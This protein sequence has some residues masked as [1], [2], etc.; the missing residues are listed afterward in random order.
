MKLLVSVLAVTAVLFCSKV[1]AA[2]LY[3]GRG[4]GT[5]VNDSNYYYGGSR[6]PQ[7]TATIDT[8]FDTVTVA[9]ALTDLSAMLAHDRLWIDSRSFYGE[10]LSA[11]EISNIQAF[12]ATGRRTVLMGER[13]VAWSTQ[14]LSIVGG[15]WAG[16]GIGIG[17]ANAL[18]VEPAL[19]KGVGSIS[20][21]QN[22]FGQSFGGVPLF[23]RPWSALWGD[24]TL[25]ILDVVVFNQWGYPSHAQYGKN[26]VQWIA[27]P[28]STTIG[29]VLL[30]LICV[31]F[32]TPR[33]RERQ[34][35]DGQEA[36]EADAIHM[37]H[38]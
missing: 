33:F 38:S 1:Y 14:I 25:T 37:P 10:P 9:P 36:R 17:V 13:G 6:W 11:T 12:I 24:N 31:A 19:T 34:R 32:S 16:E 3:I 35:K 7:L 27:A 29:L 30:G 28:E 18:P 20:F 22:G 21:A 8:T 4:A 15:T 26:V 2:S 5:R 23:D